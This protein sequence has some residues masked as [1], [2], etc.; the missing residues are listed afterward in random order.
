MLPANSCAEASMPTA[1]R[2]AVRTKD[3]GSRFGSRRKLELR[4]ETGISLSPKKRLP[5][6]YTASEDVSHAEADDGAAQ[7]DR[8]LVEAG[9]GRGAGDVEQV[10]H[11]VKPL[12]PLDDEFL[13]HPHVD[14]M[15]GGQ[16]VRAGLFRDDGHVA[17]NQRSRP[18][19]IRKL[20]ILLS[21]R[22]KP[23]VGLTLHTVVPSTD[24]QT[25]AEE[26][27]SRCLE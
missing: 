14:H 27:A 17:L 25:S 11:Q 4:T 8:R 9:H 13:L 10:Q 26:V 21:H 18:I 6:S 3:L 15:D 20:Q 2:N 7:V 5:R 24:H 16:V 23:A 22:E 1:R 19:R 12:R